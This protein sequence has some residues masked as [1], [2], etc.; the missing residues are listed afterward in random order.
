[1]PA[2]SM[3]RVCPSS[4]RL[5]C[6]FRTS[7]YASGTFTERSI[8][9][10]PVAALKAIGPG[11]LVTPLQS[12]NVK[13]PSVARTSGKRTQTRHISLER[14]RM[15]QAASSVRLDPALICCCDDGING[16]SLLTAH[17]QVHPR[18]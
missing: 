13:S 9:R 3:L 18:C 6:S 15:Q 10:S 16:I 4:K 7:P 1:M 14:G 2:Q 17:Q 5:C 8:P 12:R 11:L